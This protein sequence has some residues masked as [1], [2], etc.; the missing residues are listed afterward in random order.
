MTDITTYLASLA[1]DPDRLGAFIR[2]PEAALAESDLAEGDRLALLT[3]TPATIT[4]RLRAAAPEEP[5]P[6]LVVAAPDEDEPKA[7]LVVAAPD[8]EPHA[9]LVVAPPAEDK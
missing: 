5:R 9:P 8:D 3:R 4:G 7:P 1:V 2:D 6:P